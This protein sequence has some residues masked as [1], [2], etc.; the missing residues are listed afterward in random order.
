MSNKICGITIQGF[1]GYDSKQVFDLTTA[2]G[3]P[4]SLIVLYAPNGFGKTSFFDAVEWAL[5]GKIKRFA[6]NAVIKKSAERQ[7]GR[8]LHNYDNDQAS[9]SVEI[10]FAG[11][12][13][14]TR[15]TKLSNPGLEQWD[16][17]DGKL[18]DKSNLLP[19]GKKNVA[20]TVSILTQESGDQAI[21]FT[22]PAGRFDALK[23]FWDTDNDTNIYKS[24]LGVHKAA[25]EKREA[26]TTEIAHLERLLAE[27]LHESGIGPRMNSLIMAYNELALDELEVF[28]L[29]IEPLD[30]NSR[31]ESAIRL[32]NKAAED[33]VF[34]QD[35]RE[36]INVLF[37]G[38]A[39][40]TGKISYLSALTE[41][42]NQV[43]VRLQAVE[44]LAEHRGKLEQLRK[45]LAAE[46]HTLAQ[47]YTLKS[48]AEDFLLIEEDIQQLV[49]YSGQATT[50]L[51]TERQL[52][53]SLRASTLKL[54][55]RR[56]DLK[57][58]ED[59]REAAIGDLT[60]TA[61]AY[62]SFTAK[63]AFYTARHEV[64]RQLVARRSAVYEEHLRAVAALQDF[65]DLD[66]AALEQ[67]DLLAPAI[68]AS[69]LLEVKLAL[70]HVREAELLV[71]QAETANARA[72][73]LQQTLTGLLQLGQH[74][75]AE[76][77]ASACPLCATP[78]ADYAALHATITAQLGV[79]KDAATAANQ[80]LT[81][82][83]DLAL[84][85]QRFTVRL[86]DFNAASQRMAQQVRE[87]LL[88]HRRKLS[89]SETLSYYYQNM[90]DFATR[91]VREVEAA[92]GVEPGN[93]SI[94]ILEQMLATKRAELRTAQRY[95]QNVAQQVVDKQRQ[96]DE[97]SA[98]LLQKEQAL[99]Q[100]QRQITQARSSY[101]YQQALALLDEADPQSRELADL[102]VLIAAVESTINALEA[103][104][105]SV[106]AAIA[107][108]IPQA[109]ALSAAKLTNELREI[110]H[111][112]TGVSNEITAYLEMFAS[113]HLAENLDF[114]LALHT[115][116]QA[117][118]E[119]V[120][121]LAQ[122]QELLAGLIA[123]AEL[124]HSHLENA[125]N[126]QQKRT[127]LA[128]VLSKIEQLDDAKQQ[129]IAYIKAKIA[130]HFDEDLINELYQ[131]IEPH[132]TLKHI[133]FVPEL[134]GNKPGLDILVSDTV[135]GLDRAPVVYFSAAQ[136]NI[137][138]LS[139]FLAKALQDKAAVV[140]TIFLDDPIQFLDSI[141]MLSFI[142]LVR[143]I[144]S[145]KE[146][147]RQI[148]ISTH[149]ENFFKLLQKKIDPSYYDAKF[150]E[151]AT[152]GKVKPAPSA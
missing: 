88:V 144:I 148:V 61:E 122:Q 93:L 12:L 63:I 44:L 95:S 81:T 116:Q 135:N 119:T 62:R 52:L 130:V 10:E 85:T 32:K 14:L 60:Q 75:V 133:K 83:Q 21:C 91:Q 47:K 38:Y 128:K 29:P 109:E 79:D 42:Y 118:E 3:Q 15:T 146:L 113:L 80:L 36:K 150:I 145:S 100:T 27:E 112:R 22:T 84:V 115:E 149:D 18:T 77:E 151:L 97:L 17:N 41:N 86:E 46:N 103:D 39:T 37:A 50:M 78:F 19:K 9:G 34:L 73:D 20:T 120:L 99:E 76:T 132:P 25:S 121:L 143:I 35:K 126:L 57:S 141:N 48:V 71:Q 74:F 5:T 129:A 28:E 98:S 40:H 6:D 23:S 134:E 90:L 56:R 142:D 124:T 72:Q 92:M 4:A 104:I 87:H 54:T 64:A 140:N 2:A 43:T 53:A 108:L 102:D 24:I 13:T 30:L 67:A 89:A 111:Q 138:S 55:V 123:A 70:A 66:R 31:H 45:K 59:D 58:D 107:Q 26:L 49:S 105:L 137:L 11:D 69:Q 7:R 33:L 117:I 65:V 147:D 114:L 125:K 96:Q 94:E 131:K 106:R 16:Y 8:I 127:Q 68:L 101:L 136:V 139:I 51:Q 152:F 110:E 82:K 1:R